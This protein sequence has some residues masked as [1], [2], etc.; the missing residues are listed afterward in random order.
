MNIHPIINAVDSV[1]TKNPGLSEELSMT[2]LLSKFL[3]KLITLHRSV[4]RT[5]RHQRVDSADVLLKGMLEVQSGLKQSVA[6]L[7]GTTKKASF[8]EKMFRQLWSY[9]MRQS[10]RVAGDIRTFILEQ[11]ADLSPPSGKAP[12]THADDLI[13]SLR[14]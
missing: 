10:H 7:E 8:I 3:K 1:S 12:F 11:E 9:Q 4:S 6:K 2:S 13:R 5:P 14:S